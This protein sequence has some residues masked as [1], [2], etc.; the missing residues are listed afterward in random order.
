VSAYSETQR[1]AVHV[2][3]AGFALT[4]RYLTWPQAAVLAAAAIA[5]NAFVLAR[6]APGIMRTTDVRGVRRAPR[7][8]AARGTRSWGVLFYPIAVFVLVLVFRERL[9]IV[10]AAW[11]VMAFGDGFAT[12]VGTTAPGPRLPW[13]P[14]KSWNGLFAFIAA[15]SLGSVALCV[16]V[17]PSI[18]PVPPP[19][20][21]VIV[22]AIATV[23]AAFV[24]T[25]PIDLDDNLSVPAAAGSV[26]WIGTQID[27]A[28]V[29][30]L[31]VL[32][33]VLVSAPIAVAAWWSRA[34]TRGGALAGFACAVAIYIGTY[35]AG[36]AV[37]GVALALTIVSS[38]LGRRRKEALGIAE[39][40]G[41]RRGTGNILAN[42]AVGAAGAAL[43]AFSSDW[44]GEAG[45]LM[46]V[47]GIAA[48]ASDTVASE[49]GKPFGGTP[50]A[51]PSF[52][53]AAAGTPGAVTVI[54]TLAGVVAA[55]VIALPAVVMWLLPLER[56]PI[57]VAACTAGAFVESA[58]A[59]RFE[60]GGVLDNHTLNLLNTASAAALAVWWTSL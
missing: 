44:S 33:G 17:A 45:A 26:L 31:D 4:L 46:M 16:W 6:V 23:V 7:P 56:I 13:N 2:A 54:G 20:Y 25:M 50:R 42:C 52:R 5:F 57:V 24:E 43:A 28:P 27:Q 32:G 12:L 59:T 36:I 48:G 53:A 1:Q 47:T 22:P 38:R 15:G 49:I 18:N 35:L 29:E 39:E 41:G 9:D 11:G 51:F 8:A 40:R 34:V 14:Q 60:K 30:W 55:A 37:L 19:L 58:L 21:V 3:M 10:A